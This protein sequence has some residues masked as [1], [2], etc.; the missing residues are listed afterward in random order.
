MKNFVIF[1]GI[2][3]LSLAPTTTVLAVDYFQIDNM[4]RI[5][6]FD[7]ESLFNGLY[8][9]AISLAAILVTLR[10]IYAGIQYMF[11]EVITNKGKAKEDIKNALLGLLIILGAVTILNT[12]NP[13]LTSLGV[14]DSLDGTEQPPPP[15]V[16]AGQVIN[17]S[18]QSEAQD[19][20]SKCNG[21][22]QILPIAVNGGYQVRC[23]AN[24]D[25]PS[26]GPNTCDAGY[27][28]VRTIENGIYV[29]SCVPES[30]N[31]GGTS[32]CDGHYEQSTGIC[33]GTEI[34]LDDSFDNLD[35]NVR[36]TECQRVGGEYNFDRGIC[37]RP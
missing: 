37:Q 7:T 3:L 22:A 9:I 31:S 1:S 4:S 26:I 29:W 10:L 25:A 35:N 30:G 16:G 14:F 18:T 11:S 27:S 23:R 24:D 21:V 17:A 13:Q 5:N 28:R 6:I 12:V 34:E 20:A 19:I 33:Y 15:V 36:N 2:T 8:L 32:G